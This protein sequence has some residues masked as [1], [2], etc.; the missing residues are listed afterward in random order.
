MSFRRIALVLIALLFTDSAQAQLLNSARLAG[1]G[2]RGA[3]SAFN[4]TT[5]NASP[6]TF[7]GQISAINYDCGGQGV[8]YNV[9]TIGT[10]VCAA[11]VTTYRPDFI[12]IYA[13]GGDSGTTNLVGCN[14][15]GN[16][17]NYIVNVAS[18]GTYI[19]SM[20]VRSPTAGAAWTVSLD[21]TSVGTVG[22]PNPGTAFQDAA[23]PQFNANLGN[24]TLKFTCTTGNA[25]GQCGDFNAF[26]GK[27]SG[28]GIITFNN[29][30][31]LGNTGTS[32][33]TSLP[34]SITSTNEFLVLGLEFAGCTAP[35]VTFGGVAMTL[36]PSAITTV[37]QGGQN[38][39][40]V[41]Y[42]INPGV[43]TLNRFVVTCPGATFLYPIAAAYNDT[44]LPVF[45]GAVS[46]VDPT[47]AELA[48][49][50]SPNVPTSGDWV[51]MHASNSGNASPPISAGAG[52]TLRQGNQFNS[53]GLFDSGGPVIAGP[54]PMT[55]SVPFNNN[56]QNGNHQTHIALFVNPGGPPPPPT[57][58]VVSLTTTNF[59][60]PAA[61][62]S[63][64][65]QIKNTCLQGLCNGIGFSLSTSGSCV[66][67]N[68]NLFST[69]AANLI[70]GGSPINTPQ[71]DTI[72]IR[73]DLNG[74]TNTPTF[75]AFTLTGAT[76]VPTAMSFNPVSPVSLPDNSAIN[77]LIST[78]S[79]T[80][81]NGSA[82]SG[83]YSYS[84]DASMKMSGTG[85]GSFLETS[86]QITSADDGNHVGTITATEGGASIQSN[87]T[88]TYS[89]LPSVSLDS[90]V[91]TGTKTDTPNGGD[92]LVANITGCTGPGDCI[93]GSGGDNTKFKVTTGPWNIGV[94]GVAGY[95]GGVYLVSNGNVPGQ[96][97]GFNITLNGTSFHLGDPIITVPRSPGGQ[98]RHTTVSNVQSTINAASS[99][100]TVF[101]DA[102]SG[103]CNFNMKNGVDVVSATVQNP[104]AGQTSRAICNGGS[105]GTADNAT[106]YGLV[107]NGCSMI[108][109]TGGSG[110]VITNMIFNGP[111]QATCHGSDTN[112][113]VSWNT[114][115]S[116]A[117]LDFCDGAH[118]TNYLLLRNYFHHC[119][120]DGGLGTCIS[121]GSDSSNFN[122]R[123][124]ENF[125]D[126]GQTVIGC[127]TPF[128]GGT[129]GAIENQTHIEDGGGRDEHILGNYSIN[130][131]DLMFSLP[132]GHTPMEVRY[133]Y[134]AGIGPSIEWEPHDGTNCQA[135][136]GVDCT[137]I[138][139]DNYFDNTN[140][141]SGGNVGSYGPYSNSPGSVWQNNR[142][143]PGIGDNAQCCGGSLSSAGVNYT[144]GPTNNIGIPPPFASGA[145][146]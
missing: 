15:V 99:G 31:D 70:V 49:T 4:G 26:T 1:G 55:T 113:T 5:C 135:S 32:P 97:G 86:R 85:P 94:K 105:I 65:A 24:H 36:D 81:S 53:D 79:V 130:A 112:V 88:V 137:D 14:L 95:R 8:A 121:T 138:V 73:S 17:M 133:N 87:F 46:T 107:C 9:P 23:T 45:D 128:N 57:I 96:T 21:G 98:V 93:L 58:G 92:T 72:C 78:P 54:L 89:A 114:Y 144:A 119:P 141:G 129:C 38:P 22:V 103:G 115:N 116:A 118:S 82:F 19:V 123:Y 134:L 52:A 60:V 3:E 44:V 28:S 120:D 75:T 29:S 83:T 136:F 35:S 41:F 146:P 122:N 48:Y 109:T 62:G 127:N 39:A 13:S 56:G 67:T 80:T 68:N 77:T 33:F 90:L 145:G 111:R 47:G 125:F 132:G 37:A 142:E 126:T 143:T 59:A 100:D 74:A 11:P 76:V 43:S 27:V 34:F 7:L 117:G 42:M 6:W 124:Y 18:T 108:R 101:V 69:S 61:A 50:S 106:L 91:F 131:S 16:S 71:T 25:S 2:T 40:A 10:G 51:M 104:M 20:R 30:S 140:L 102:S 64:I 12:N 84:G 110:R 139:T 63:P 66:G